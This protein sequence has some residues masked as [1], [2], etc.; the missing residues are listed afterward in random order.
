MS[1]CCTAAAAAAVTVVVVGVADGLAAASA[2]QGTT[3][4]AV[5]DSGAEWLRS[6]QSEICSHR[7][8]QHL[9]E[10]EKDFTQY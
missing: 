3:G 10:R 1:G 7:L 4:T 2:P 9:K 8:H 5:A 6:C